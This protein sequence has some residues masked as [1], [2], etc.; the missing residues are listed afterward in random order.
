MTFSISSYHFNKP[1]FQVIAEDDI[2]GVS[3]NSAGMITKSIKEIDHN[4]S[5]TD[6]I[7]NI[8]LSVGTYNPE[9]PI[10]IINNTAFN[11]TA[12]NKSWQ[13]NGT[14]INPY[15]INNLN[16]TSSSSNN[17]IDIQDTN[18]YFEIS[19][20]YLS[21]GFNAIALNNVSN[22]WISNNIITNCTGPAI[23]PQQCNDTIFCD[24]YLFKNSYSGFHLQYCENT[25]ILNNTLTNGS[26]AIQVSDS[27]N[28]TINNND[29]SFYNSDGIS[30]D[31][32]FSIVSGN[33]LCGCHIRV[34]VSSDYSIVEDNLI[35]NYEWNRH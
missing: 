5:P 26:T 30:V 25:T 12:Y 34:H 27:R 28:T 17:L 29:I 11:S 18:V 22:G 10:L 3:L 24:N 2:Q 13:G 32:T 4:F 14:K 20:C 1:I 21:T 35:Y 16:I 19:D 8:I 6:P 9:N 7:P 33:V 23:S 31:S 15:I